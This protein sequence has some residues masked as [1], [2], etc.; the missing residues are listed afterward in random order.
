MANQC[1]IDWP[2]E[3]LVGQS[4]ILVGKWPMAD[5]YI[6]LWQLMLL[7]YFLVC[8]PFYGTLASYIN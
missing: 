4:C 2:F 7:F 3:M 6:V 5:C 1:E 8:V